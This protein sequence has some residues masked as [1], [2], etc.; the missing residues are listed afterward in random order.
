MCIKQKD[1]NLHLIWKLKKLKNRD[2]IRKL[3]STELE[4]T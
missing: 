4:I 3:E 1:E 2:E